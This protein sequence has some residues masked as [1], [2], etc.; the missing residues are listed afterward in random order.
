MASA[1][2]T[3]V[4]EFAGVLAILVDGRPLPNSMQILRIHLATSSRDRKICW[5][6]GW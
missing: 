5:Y 6:A 2:I 1:L 4:N 3:L